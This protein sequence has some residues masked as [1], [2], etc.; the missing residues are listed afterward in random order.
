[1]MSAIVVEQA[2]KAFEPFYVLKSKKKKPFKEISCLTK[3]TLDEV[4]DERK[5]ISFCCSRTYE[6]L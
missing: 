6:Q 3:V 4:R 5:L 2:S 1:M